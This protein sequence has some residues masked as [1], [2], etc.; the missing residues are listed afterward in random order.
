M[1]ACNFSHACHHGRVLT[2]PAYCNKQ[3][4]FVMLAMQIHQSL[5]ASVEEAIERVASE[6]K[7]MDI[8][9]FGLI[10]FAM[11]LILVLMRIFMTV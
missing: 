11:P 6:C 1:N 4:Y 10:V 8:V 9:V 5:T 3:A 7:H 2:S